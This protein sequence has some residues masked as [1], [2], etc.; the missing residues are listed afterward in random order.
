[1]VSSRKLT[2]SDFGAWNKVRAE[3]LDFEPMAFGRSNA[4]E[5][6]HREQLFKNNIG[7]DDRFI[8][9]LF[10]GD[11]L[12][13]IGGFFRHEPVKAFHKGIIWSVF[14]KP[15]YQGK[16][17]GRKLMEVVLSEATVMDGLESILIG[18]SSNNPPAI[19]LYKNLGFVEY[20]REQNCL[21][22]DGKYVDQILMRMAVD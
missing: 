9:G 20:G 15:E 2:L 10:D 19:N 18:V 13:A 1:M 8:I 16:G 22:H 4:D 14:V 6:A 3:A 11:T 7:R 12:I 21:K 17:I 5:E